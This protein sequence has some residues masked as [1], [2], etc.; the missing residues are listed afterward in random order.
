M[1]R[2]VGGIE[3]SESCIWFPK[4]ISELDQCNHVL[5]KL[6]PDLGIHFID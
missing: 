5:T 4:H 1:I 6:E 2:L 3:V